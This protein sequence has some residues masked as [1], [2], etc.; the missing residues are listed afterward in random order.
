MAVAATMRRMR[1]RVSGIV[2]GVGFRPHVY[3]L[4]CELDLS[5]CVLN[6][7]RG[8]LLEVEGDPAV[9]ARFLK[10]LVAEAPPLAKIEHVQP[11]AIPVTGAI[12]FEILPSVRAGVANALVSPDTATCPECLVELNDPCDRRYRY[13]FINCTNCGPRFTIATGVPY[14]RPLTTMA[15]FVMCELCR[16]E[17]EDPGNRRFHAQPNA[18]PA[19]GPHTRLLWLDGSEPAGGRGAAGEPAGRHV[20]GDAVA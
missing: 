2:Q 16:A 12:A 17:Y 8:V 3:R 7:E 9:L 11:Q 20:A 14:D 6:D 13:P 5:G 19:C 15:G 1:V 10:R 4:A 18:C